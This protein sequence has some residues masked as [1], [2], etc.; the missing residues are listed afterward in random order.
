MYIYMIYSKCCPK[1][2]LHFLLTSY[3]LFSATVVLWSAF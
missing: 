3:Y 2:V 1:N